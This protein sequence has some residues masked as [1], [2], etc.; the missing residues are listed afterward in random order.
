MAD[1]NFTMSPQEYSEH[2]K[3]VELRSIHCKRYNVKSD[4][5]RT[6]P[7]MNIDIKHSVSYNIDS[8][9][10]IIEMIYKLKAYKDKKSEFAIQIDCTIE[11]EL[12]SEYSFNEEFLKIY[13]DV[14]LNYNT[15][16]YFREFVQSATQR[17][18]L[19]PLTLPFY[20]K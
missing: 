13:L 18:G 9:T 10:A 8:N 5:K 11:V 17:A 3:K 14:N 6:A 2:L 7:Q 16:P 12:E 1:N 4:K 15:W 20:K 19:P